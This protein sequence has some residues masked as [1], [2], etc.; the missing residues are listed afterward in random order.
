L[1]TTLHA[2][3]EISVMNEWERKSL[4]RLQRILLLSPGFGPLNSSG[5]PW[6]GFNS[7]KS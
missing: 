6:T 5:F 7:R 2:E 3:A 1:A 4:P